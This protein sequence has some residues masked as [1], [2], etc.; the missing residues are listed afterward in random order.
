MANK[1]RSASGRKTAI[2]ANTLFMCSEKSH[3]KLTTYESPIIYVFFPLL[4]FLPLF[5]FFFF[6]I[7]CA[8]VSLCR[9]GDI[10][11]TTTVNSF[12][13]LF[14]CYLVI[15]IVFN[16]FWAHHFVLRSVDEIRQNNSRFFFFFSSHLFLGVGISSLENIVMCIKRKKLKWTNK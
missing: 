7:L 6:S 10:R 5:F 11:N 12:V 14:L 13:L 1:T 3:L 2:A 8:N 15:S 4:S 9:D 16:C